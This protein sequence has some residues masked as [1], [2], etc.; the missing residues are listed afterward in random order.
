MR[1]PNLIVAASRF[2]PW[3][4]MA[5]AGLSGILRRGPFRSSVETGCGGSSIVLSHASDHH[6]A[7]AIEGKALLN[8]N[9]Y[10]RRR[11]L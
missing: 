2:H 3:D 7:F 9:M 8:N 4:A 1:D 5:P 10:N 11:L 6:I